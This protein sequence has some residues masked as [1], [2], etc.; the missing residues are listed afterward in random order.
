M[1]AVNTS[2]LWPPFSDPVMQSQQVFRLI[3]KAMSEPGS[4]VSFDHHVSFD[5]SPQTGASNI[6]PASFITA[7][8]LLDQDTRV[9]LSNIMGTPDFI[10][11][12]RFHC[13]CRL[14]ESSL[15]ADFVF[16]SI[17]EWSSFEGFKSGSDENPHYSATLIIQA[18]K[19]FTLSE[20][21]SDI[22]GRTGGDFFEESAE[23][24]GENSETL[25]LSGPGVPNKRWV[26]VPGLNTQHVRLLQ[27]NHQ[28]YPLGRDLLFTFGTSLMALPR[29]T[30][31]DTYVQRTDP[32]Q[33]VVESC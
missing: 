3:L 32:A 5:N 25:I 18:A 9:W 22:N 31:V 24:F 1:Q 23:R 4:L 20:V 19:E 16:M 21:A 26:Q 8:T 29:S 13:G 28:L 12:L 7:L 2:R 11:N 27:K 30:K 6:A 33:T 17:D 10:D 14:M 15:Q